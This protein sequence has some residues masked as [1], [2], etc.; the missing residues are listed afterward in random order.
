MTRRGYVPLGVEQSPFVFA[1]HL[2][3]VTAAAEGFAIGEIRIS[4]LTWAECRLL[5]KTRFMDDLQDAF[6]YGREPLFI[7]FSGFP[8][9]DDSQV[10][11]IKNNAVVAI[12]RLTRALRLL[13]SGEVW[14]PLEFVLYMRRDLLKN[15]RDPRL[16]GRL[17]F[18]SRGDLF[19]N[20]SMEDIACLDGLYAALDLFD[21]FRYDVEIDRAEAPLAAS[22]S[23]AHINFVHR[24]L[25][26]L[27]ALEILAGRD[28]EPLA[29]AEWA[30]DGLRR[31]IET[32]SSLR[33]TL[34]HGR[35]DDPNDLRDRLET[36]R[37]ATRVLMREA[38]AWRLLE[39]GAPKV[40][41]PPLLARALAKE[42][43]DPRRLAELQAPY[44][45]M[46]PAD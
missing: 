2:P 45:S 5:E 35:S 25:P 12:Q 30:D 20:L 6:V 22:F 17:A 7:V 27:G 23:P 10:N 15:T 38:I 9:D 26:L 41:G 28:L 37:T 4:K 39:P 13:K 21:R 44:P 1:A 42:A 29:K 32:Y 40:T 31:W 11:L 18:A 14:D 24:I 36:T 46:R 8:G 33:N 34:A 19:V 43:A 3:G 16:F